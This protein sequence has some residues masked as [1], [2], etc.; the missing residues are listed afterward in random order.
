MF[1]KDPCCQVYQEWEPQG[2]RVS[3]DITISSVESDSLSPTSFVGARMFRNNVVGRILHKSKNKTFTVNNFNRYKNV[4]LNVIAF[5]F[6]NSLSN[7]FQ[8]EMWSEIKIKF[9]SSLYYIGWNGLEQKINLNFWMHV[10]EEMSKENMVA[11]LE[12]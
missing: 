1:T 2:I 9:F 11:Y 8:V 4:P 7:S 10:Q 5:T 12:K 6:I 3:D